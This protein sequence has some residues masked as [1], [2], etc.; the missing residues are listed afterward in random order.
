MELKIE[1]KALLKD[2]SSRDARILQLEK[3][4]CRTESN[5]QDALKKEC[6]H[7]SENARNSD[8][9]NGAPTVNKNALLLEES[10]ARLLSRIKFL[11]DRMEAK[12]EAIRQLETRVEVGKQANR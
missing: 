9:S 4:L 5:L 11:S 6:C 2:I 12:D 1:K 7:D 10:N 3:D 8:I